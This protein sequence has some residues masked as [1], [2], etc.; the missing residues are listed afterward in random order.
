MFLCPTNPILTVNGKLSILMLYR[1]RGTRCARAKTA[2]THALLGNTVDFLIS[3][4][5]PDL[6]SRIAVGRPGAQ[7]SVES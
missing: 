6:A 1:A 2:A 4:E 5:M 3:R 7:L